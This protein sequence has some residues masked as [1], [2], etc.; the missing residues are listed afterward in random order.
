MT[1]HADALRHLRHVLA[2]YQLCANAGQFALMPI[3]MN[4]EE[5][6][7]NHQAEHGVAQ[8]FQALVV[9]DSAKVQCAGSLAA[10]SLA[11]DR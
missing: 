9:A 2:A 7:G 5:G 10:C 3:G 4:T 8:K 11:S 6:L 1:A